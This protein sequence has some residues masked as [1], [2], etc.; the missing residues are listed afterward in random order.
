MPHFGFG[1]VNKN[2][3]KTYKASNGAWIFHLNKRYNM[4]LMHEFLCRF[5]FYPLKAQNTFLYSNKWERNCDSPHIQ[6]IA[7][8]FK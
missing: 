6:F 5:F 3:F 2:N 8:F 4:I 7:V 1:K